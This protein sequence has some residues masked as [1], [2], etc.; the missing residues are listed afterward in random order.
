MFNFKNKYMTTIYWILAIH[1][2]TVAITYPF[3]VIDI[4]KVCEDKPE[5]F[6]FLNYRILA[7]VASFVPIYNLYVGFKAFVSW[8]VMIM[9]IRKLKKKF[10]KQ[11]ASP[12]L[13]ED[14]DIII[15][16]LEKY[17]SNKD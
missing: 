1:L 3:I 14:M 11:S 7:I 15:K 6:S 12:E 4:K 9:I 5:M 10:N 16:A 8:L 2:F 13:K 17:N